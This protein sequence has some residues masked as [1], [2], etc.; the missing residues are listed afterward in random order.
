MPDIN[1]QH[2]LAVA[3]IDGDLTFEAAHSFDRMKDPAVLKIRNRITLKED[4]ELVPYH[5]II[6]VILNNGSMLTEYVTTVLGRP[7][8][9]MTKELIDKRCNTLMAP[10]LGEGRSLKLIDKIWN[11]EQVSNMR[12]LRPLL[13]AP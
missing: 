5:S 13:S 11:L 8:N 3:L 7:D 4:H 12:E 10:I 2:L 1:L 6:K 9:P